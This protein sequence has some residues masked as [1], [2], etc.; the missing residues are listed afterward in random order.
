MIHFCYA[1]MCHVETERSNVTA[2]PPHARHGHEVGWRRW[3]GSCL[4][5]VHI[6]LS[7]LANNVSV[8]NL[9]NPSS[10]AVIVEAPVYCQ[11]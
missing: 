9:N 6:E 2:Q 8:L 3:L 4:P 5:L 7:P 10:V 11:P 1:K